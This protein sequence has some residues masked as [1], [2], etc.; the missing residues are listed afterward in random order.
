MGRFHLQL[1]YIHQLVNSSSRKIHNKKQL[2]A[3]NLKSRWNW[4]FFFHSKSHFRTIMYLCVIESSYFFCLSSYDC[5]QICGGVIVNENQI[6]T[7]AHCVDESKNIIIIPAQFAEDNLKTKLSPS[8]YQCQELEE[9]EYR[10][11]D[12]FEI[13][14]N[15][16][17]ADLINDIAIV[18][19][20]Q[21]FL[22]KD[23]EIMPFQN[24]ANGLKTELYGLAPRNATE[25]Y[26]NQSIDNS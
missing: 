1:T 7:A 18:T 11:I 13:H 21:K 19:V 8:N 24:K 17:E 3:I 26:N 23:H 4:H 9:H 20:D 2:S 25:T 10:E 12:S 14:D 6:I 22:F 5:K 15:Y 16:Q